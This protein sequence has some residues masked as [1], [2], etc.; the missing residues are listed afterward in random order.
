MGGEVNVEVDAAPQQDL[1]ALMSEIR[2]HYEAV[3][4]KNGKEL[5]AWFQT[6]VRP[7]LQRDLGEI[8]SSQ[9]LSVVSY[10]QPI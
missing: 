1:A 10:R 9:T 3:A 7:G 6:M 4:A 2:Q 5:E 8:R